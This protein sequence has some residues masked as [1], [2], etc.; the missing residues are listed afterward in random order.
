MVTDEN[1][2]IL[3]INNAWR[4]FE[5]ERGLLTDRYGVGLNYLELRKKAG[6]ASGAERAIAD[7]IGQVLRG[8]RS[9]FDQQYSSRNGSER[10]WIRLHAAPV[11]LFE[12]CRVLVTHDDLTSMEQFT[13]VMRK[14]AEHLRL[15][16][17]VTH[18]FPWEADF[19]SSSFTYVGEQAV[20]MLGYPLDDWYRSDFW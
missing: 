9:H 6:D 10:R 3:Q 1:G 11:D 12:A 7:G 16:L 13:E 8:L 4:E 2:T 19:P 17:E 18:V 20:N 5:I 14:E 15:L